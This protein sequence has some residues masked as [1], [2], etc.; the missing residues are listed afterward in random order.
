MIIER[1]G[2]DLECCNGIDC[3]QVNKQVN[4]QIDT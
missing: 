2:S 3:K 1:D 4:K